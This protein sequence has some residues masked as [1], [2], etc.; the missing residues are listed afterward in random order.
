MPE[1][2]QRNTAPSVSPWHPL[3]IGIFCN[4]LVADPVSDVG[5]FMQT[6]DAAWLMTM[7]TK[8]SRYIALIQF[9]EVPPCRAAVSGSWWQ[10]S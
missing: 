2:T 3:R 6:V 9:G 10:P 4:L 1:I 5:A 7:L 8:S